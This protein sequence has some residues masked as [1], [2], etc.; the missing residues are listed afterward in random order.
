[1]TKFAEMLMTDAQVYENVALGWLQFECKEDILIVH[2]SRTLLPTN[3][4]HLF[5]RNI[6]LP[7][8]FKGDMLVSWMVFLCEVFDGM[9][10]LF[11]LYTF[12]SFSKSKVEGIF[13]NRGGS[14][15]TIG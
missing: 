13:S 2:S 6:I 3:I 10:A 5:K 11:K 1:M 7:A 12:S 9:N 14:H 15:K 8:S 4:S